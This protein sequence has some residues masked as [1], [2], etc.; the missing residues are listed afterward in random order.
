MSKAFI[1]LDYKL[2]T[3]DYILPK[4]SGNRIDLFAQQDNPIRQSNNHKVISSGFWLRFNAPNDTILCS[5]VFNHFDGDPVPLYF[6]VEN[7]EV[8]FLIPLGR[9]CPVI[10]KGDRIG[11]LVVE[12]IKVE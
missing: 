10:K 6:N 11:S 3:S 1:R 5:Y 4:M 2:D 12:R 7:V 9:E 8:V